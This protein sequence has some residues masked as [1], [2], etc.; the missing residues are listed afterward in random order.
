MSWLNCTFFDEYRLTYRR[1]REGHSRGATGDASDV[2]LKAIAAYQ[3]GSY[4]D[5]PSDALTNASSLSGDSAAVKPDE[6]DSIN[7]TQDPRMLKVTEWRLQYRRFRMGQ[8]RGS[9]G[10]LPA[11]IPEDID[12]SF[13]PVVQLVRLRRQ[14]N[15]EASK[16]QGATKAVSEGY[17]SYHVHLGSG[18]LGLGLILKSLVAS[19]RPFILLQNS[20]GMWLELRKPVELA[21]G[22]GVSLVEVEYGNGEPS[23]KLG[24]IH[25]D[26]KSIEHIETLSKLLPAVQGWMVVTN[27]P[28]QKK[29]LIEQASTLSI[30][31]GSAA[32]AA[33][34]SLLEEVLDE[35]SSKTIFACENDHAAV[36]KLQER[37]KDRAVVIPCMVDRICSGLDTMEENGD[38]KVK[39]QTEAYAGEIVVLKSFDGVL[40]FGGV[41]VKSPSLDI[42]GNYFADRKFLLVN[43]GH[44]TLAFLTML[45]YHNNEARF[46]PPG[47]DKLLDWSTCTDEERAVFWSFTIARLLLLLWQYDIDVL[48]D[49]HKVHTEEELVEALLTYA[50]QTVIRFNAIPDT[51]NRILSGGVENRY[52]GRLRNIEDFIDMHFDG[53]NLASKKLLDVCGCRLTGLIASIHNFVSRCK[54]FVHLQAAFDI[55]L[56]NLAS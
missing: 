17:Q 50:K 27:D 47:C 4:I 3:D 12:L 19:Q 16:T 55:V 42:Q 26:L 31:V 23:I 44:T 56:P 49:A 13:L 2:G 6:L 48:K 14:M 30:S 54:Q 20:R 38:L 37:L 24:L 21:S 7:A 46:V 29:R 33:I 25:E 35:S 45:R 9:V 34:G 39:V 51:T 41:E 10:E 36:E 11:I 32:I 28:V 8:A 15:R 40:P 52:H 18:K 22:I 5:D 1:F 43:G 53:S